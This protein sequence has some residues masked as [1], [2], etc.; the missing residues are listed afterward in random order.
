MVAMNFRRYEIIGYQNMERIKNPYKDIPDC[1][2]CCYAAGTMWLTARQKSICPFCLEQLDKMGVAIN[3]KTETE[4]A[5]IQ[6]PK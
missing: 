3:E 1:D 6:H 2:F 4:D 5:R